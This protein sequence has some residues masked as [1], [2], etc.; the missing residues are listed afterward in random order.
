MIINQFSEFG[1]HLVHYLCT[2]RALELIYDAV[3]AESAGANLHAFVSASGSAGTLGAGDYLKDRYGTL[4]AAVEAL[5][6]P[7][8]L[9]NGFGE[10][11]IQG[12]GDKHVPLIH[13]VMNTDVVVDITD[14][15]TDQ[16]V[17]MFNNDAGRPISWRD[18]ASRAD[19]VGALTSLGHL[20]HL[21]RAG[22]DQAR[23]VLGRSG[24][25]DVIIT[26]ATDGA[27]MYGSEQ[28]KAL[29]RDFPDGF[30]A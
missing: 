27:G 15:A 8:L 13:N 16:L 11:N 23:E 14:R 25:D 17:V 3:A 9:R 4:I 18:G 5:E 28:D 1:N 22:G 12:I 29:A 10:H 19:L 7:T 20:E 6:C 2:G 26:V 30:G 21:Q 24:P